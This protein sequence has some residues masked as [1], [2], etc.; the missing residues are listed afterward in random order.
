METLFQVARNNRL[1]SDVAEEIE[2][3]WQGLGAPKPPDGPSTSVKGFVPQW[4]TEDE[5]DADDMTPF[6]IESAVMRYNH[7]LEQLLLLTGIWNVGGNQ[8]NT[9]WEQGT[10][11]WQ[12]YKNGS[13]DIACEFVANRLWDRFCAGL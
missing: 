3:Y 7:A 6:E 9:T 1:I 8:W 11:A 10:D 12:T 13:W 4:L 5:F 2:N